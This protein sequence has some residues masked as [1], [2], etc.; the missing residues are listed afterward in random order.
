MLP[1]IVSITFDLSKINKQLC[2][3]FFI[4]TNEGSFVIEVLQKS[5][6]TQ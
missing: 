4:Q 1:V 2:D 5:A 3:R 6:K